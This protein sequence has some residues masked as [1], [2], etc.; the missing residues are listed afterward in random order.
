MR[1][2]VLHAVVAG[3]RRRGLCT[4]G[5]GMAHIP[6]VEAAWSRGEGRGSTT[7]KLAG[8]WGS[9]PDPATAGGSA[10]RGVVWGGDSG[11]KWLSAH[12]TSPALATWAK[13]WPQSGM[14]TRRGEGFAPTSVIARWKLIARECRLSPCALFRRRD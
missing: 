10:A 14:I 9:V 2:R 11:V 4:G 5:D 1:D 8:P 13:S 7:R 12:S 3:G 6:A